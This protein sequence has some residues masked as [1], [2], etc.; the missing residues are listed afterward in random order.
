MYCYMYKGLFS[1]V[2]KDCYET[3]YEQ[4]HLA[5]REMLT[6]KHC[7]GLILRIDLRS[8]YFLKNSSYLVLRVWKN[9]HVFLLGLRFEEDL[10][11][12][13]VIRILILLYNLF[14]LYRLKIFIYNFVISS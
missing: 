5:L 4:T 12:C 9:V 8:E 3:F 1:N 2:T 6:T 10:F 11:F 14:T 7:C 13:L